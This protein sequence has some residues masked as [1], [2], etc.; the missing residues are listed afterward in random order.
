MSSS[1]RFPSRSA[2][3][4]DGRDLPPVKR[5]AIAELGYG[6]NAKVLVGFRAVRGRR[7]ATPGTMNTDEALQLAGRTAPADGDPSGGLTLYSGG[8]P[9]IDRRQ[10]HRSKPS[11]PACAAHR[12]RLSR[13]P[14]KAGMG[15]SRFHWPTFPLTKGGHAATNRPRDDDRRSRGRAGREPLLRGR[16]RQL[17]FPG[18]H[19][20]RRAVRCGCRRGRDVRGERI[21]QGGADVLSSRARGRSH[22]RRRRHRNDG[23]AT[24]R[25]QANQSEDVCV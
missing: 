3:S 5:K 12:A 23:R 18:L 17:R 1:W 14:R 8:K 25:L 6:A 9:A 7:R 2:R 13:V 19:E 15:S 11:R 16:A 22:D 24:A 10:G 21:G 20:R 4:E